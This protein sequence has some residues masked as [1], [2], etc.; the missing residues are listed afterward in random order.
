MPDGVSL[1]GSGEMQGGKLP[2]G[3]KPQTET[4]IVALASLKGDVVTL[5]DGASLQKLTIADVADRSGNAVGVRSR[6]PFDSVTASIVECEIVNPSEGGGNVDGPEGGG[7]VVMTRN[8]GGPA[9]PRPD[10]GARVELS[11]SRS[12]VRSAKGASALFAINSASAGR[13]DIHL[14]ENRFEGRL[15]VVGGIPR[16]DEVTGAEIAIHSSDNLYAPLVPFPNA[17]TI[18]GGSSPPPF[19]PSGPGASSGHVRVDSSGDR[20]EKTVLG[21]MA[22]ASRRFGMQFG[23]NSDNRVVLNVR[24][25]TLKTIAAEGVRPADFVLAGAASMGPGPDP[26]LSE[27]PPGDR[28]VVS[29]LLRDTKGSRRRANSYADVSGPRFP[30]NVGIG[31]RLEFFGTTVEFANSNSQINPAPPDKFFIN[32]A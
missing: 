2:T 27:F 31:N 16:G 32:P 22:M 17:W 28:N 9:A 23:P 5:G 4:K 14:T 10:T 1:V 6:A 29:V 19:F 11:M 30:W 13:L 8:P 3:F 15:D 18:V 26:E 12:I 7:I 25:L 21:I 20:I 24:A